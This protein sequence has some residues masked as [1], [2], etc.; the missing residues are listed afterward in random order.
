MPV[1][2][3]NRPIGH[4]LNTTDIEA[5]IL[6]SGGDALVYTGTAHGLS[7]GDYVYIESN[8]DTYNGF[9][10]VDSISYDAFKIKNY[11][12]SGYVPFKQ[13]TEISFRVSVLEHGWQCVHLPIVYEL[14]S[15]IWPTNDVYTQSAVGGTGSV[16]GYLELSFAPP[17]E[18]SALDYVLVKFLLPD[19]GFEFVPVQVLSETDNITFT[20]IVIDM[21]V[22]VADEL[23]D[24]Y[25]T[26]IKYYTNYFIGV[27][28]YGGLPSDHPWYA[29]KPYELLGTL[30]LIPDSDNKVKFSISEILKGQINT[31]NNLTL[32]TLPNNIDFWTG[33]Y[34][35]YF[36]SFDTSDGVDVST[37]NS[38]AI[39]DQSEFEGVATNSILPFKSLNMGH[40]SDY[41]NEDSYPARWLTLQDVPIAFVDRFF[42]LSFI[43]TYADID[44]IITIFKSYQG[45]VTDTDVTTIENP[46]IG[47]IRVPITPESG[48]DRYC[49]QAS[50][51]VLSESINIPALTTWLTRSTSAPLID[52]TTGASPNVTLA[53]AGSLSPEE[54]EDL[55]FSYAFIED[56]E[57]S[58]SITYTRV[59]NSGS[60]N[61]RTT[62]ISVFDS[63]FNTLHS[64]TQAANSGSNTI[65]IVFTANGDEEMVGI[66]HSS[67][68]NVTLTINSASGSRTIPATVITEQICINIAEECGS[69]FVDDNL[70]LTEGGLFRELE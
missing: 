23:Y 36:E 19:G 34:I 35:E 3:I 17:I 11:E 24:G 37:Y 21:L 45:V 15:D 42:D 44:I 69:T 47:I 27:N 22:E 51:Q 28:V 25:F 30:R 50:T 68:A 14:E 9:K 65:T 39:S 5:T 66:R 41:V 7:D 49:I 55:Y 10:Y 32:D 26:V 33:F 54:S 64:D 6:D 56:Q 53:G 4:K 60:G 18:L 2:V 59:V 40:M 63:S 20:T 52:W 58:V 38:E 46:G 70:R 43:N 16:N 48:F 67:G 8:F 12:G 29:E 61:P 13:V 1:T 62:T 31:R 57:Y